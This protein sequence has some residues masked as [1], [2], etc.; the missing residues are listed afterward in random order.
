MI[1]IDPSEPVRL[2][3]GWI[4]F[5]AFAGSLLLGGLVDRLYLYVQIRRR[6]PHLRPEE[7][8]TEPDPRHGQSVYDVSGVTPVPVSDDERLAGEIGQ[9]HDY[10]LYGAATSLMPRVGDEEPTQVI[11]RHR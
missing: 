4:A 11:R 2:A 8:E 6:R 1:G 7:L 3:S 9:L 5:G 10:Q